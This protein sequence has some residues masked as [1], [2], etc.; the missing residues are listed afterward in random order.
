[1]DKLI[2]IFGDSAAILGLFICLV[3]GISRLAGSY[4]VGG[5]EAMTLFTGGIAIML[6]ATLAK[7]Y[8]IENR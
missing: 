5:Y 4:N 8:R 7:L 2:K 3:A 1:M 6:A